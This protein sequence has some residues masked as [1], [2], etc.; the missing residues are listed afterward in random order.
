MQWCQASTAWAA[1]LLQRAR[2]CQQVSSKHV[3][4]A[5]PSATI[6][7]SA[8]V[9]LVAVAAAGALT[10]AKLCQAV[11]ALQPPGCILVDE[12]LTSGSTYWEAAKVC[13]AEEQAV[14][15]SQPVVLYLRA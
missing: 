3:L 7:F 2:H 9:Q 1:S 14:R 4:P 12:A 8:G 11:A 5:A 13:V 10:P 6:C 15:L